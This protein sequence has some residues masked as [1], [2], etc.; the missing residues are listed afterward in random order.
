MMGLPVLAR[1]GVENLAGRCAIFE[2]G[3]PQARRPRSATPATLDETRPLKDGTER[4]ELA[5]ACLP[6]W[7]AD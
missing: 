4:R 7:L 3:A 2:R 1:R 5:A 6:D